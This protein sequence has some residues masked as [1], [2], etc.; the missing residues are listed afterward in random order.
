[1][2]KVFKLLEENENY[3]DEDS[4]L[5]ATNFRIILSLTKELIYKKVVLI[6]PLPPNPDISPRRSSSE[7][8]TQ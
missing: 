2:I 8:A 1:M 3:S 7:N 5:N 4:N 6:A